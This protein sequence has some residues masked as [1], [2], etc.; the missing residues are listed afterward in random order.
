MYYLELSQ[1]QAAICQRPFESQRRKIRI[2]TIVCAIITNTAVLVRFSTRLGLHQ[3]FGVDDWFIA[4]TIVSPYAFVI[5]V[6]L[7]TLRPPGDRCSL[8]IFRCTT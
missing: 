4:A 7:L 2:M 6:S 5:R 1:I 8:Y 3:R